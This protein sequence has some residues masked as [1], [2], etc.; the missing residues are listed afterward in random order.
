MKKGFT[1]IELLITIII[2]WLLFVV[3]FRAYT[4]ISQVT[5]RT[6]QEKNIQQELIRISQTLQNI[7]DISE[8]DYESYQS[9]NIHDTLF[10]S[11]NDGKIKINSTGNCI[12]DIRNFTW[13]TQ[14]QK[15]NPCLLTITKEDG[16][17][18][19]LN[20]PSESIISKPYFTTSPIRTNENIIW[21][22]NIQFPFLHIEQPGF[23]V[24]FTIFTPIYKK[25]Q[26]TNT[27]KIIFQQFFK[28][29]K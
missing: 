13:F 23:Q 8:I 4:T 22:N 17:I 15:E 27:S 12:S 28:L 19:V 14:E 7:A 18:I 2:I 9:T 26:R 3:L 29:Q 11:W 6:Q 24:Y 25:N 21:D 10:L 16:N 20:S 1:L 5:F